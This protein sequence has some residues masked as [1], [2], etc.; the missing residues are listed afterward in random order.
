MPSFSENVVF[1]FYTSSLS[2]NFKNVWSSWSSHGF[3]Y[4]YNRQNFQDFSCG[5][6]HYEQQIQL[7]WGS[8]NSCNFVTLRIKQAL[9]FILH[10]PTNFGFQAPLHKEVSKAQN[11]NTNILH[12]SPSTKC[13]NIMPTSSRTSQMCVQDFLEISLKCAQ[14]LPQLTRLKHFEKPDFLTHHGRIHYAQEVL[15]PPFRLAFEI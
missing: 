9:R 4:R 11:A 3:Q 1:L 8:V 13:L 2:L 10:T 14:W 6:V 5:H 7:R 15:P 12:Y